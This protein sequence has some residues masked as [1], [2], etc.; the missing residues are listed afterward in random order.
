[1]N[2]GGSYVLVDGVKIP[3]DE[4][5]KQQKAKVKKPKQTETNND[6]ESS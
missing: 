5:E 3:K 2:K 1:M 4:Y 6:E